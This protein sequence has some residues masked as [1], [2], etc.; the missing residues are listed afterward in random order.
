MKTLV[1]INDA[2]VVDLSMGK[3]NA[4]CHNSVESVLSNIMDK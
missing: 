4:E 1:F 2:I 3:L